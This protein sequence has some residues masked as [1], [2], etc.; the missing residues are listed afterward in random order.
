MTASIMMVGPLLIHLRV[1]S[2]RKRQGTRRTKAESGRGR[3][4]APAKRGSS[5]SPRVP[6]TWAR[7]GSARLGA[8]RTA[9]KAVPASGAGRPAGGDGRRALIRR[10]LAIRCDATSIVEELK[11]AAF[12][13]F[14]VHET[15][16]CAQVLV[17][18]SLYSETGTH[19]KSP[20][21]ISVG[22]GALPGREGE[23]S[24]VMV[25]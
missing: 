20:A 5:T 16:V 23:F 24:C 21:L 25:Y 7:Q 1:E 17:I 22:T 4:A 3:R 8:E 15:T 11:L 2:A 12:Y 10:C 13:S 9:S 6:F 18:T 19:S 14:S